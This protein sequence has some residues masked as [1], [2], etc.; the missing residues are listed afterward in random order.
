[1]KDRRNNYRRQDE[2]NQGNSFQYPVHFLFTSILHSNTT[3]TFIGRV[4]IRLS[5]IL[6]DTRS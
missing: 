4:S 2:P 6:A 1:M 3:S 5:G